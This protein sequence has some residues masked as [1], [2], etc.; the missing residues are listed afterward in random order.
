MGFKT[1]QDK[2]YINGD[3]VILRLIKLDYKI[4][5]FMKKDLKLN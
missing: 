4:Q 1:D 3:N 2:E 5:K